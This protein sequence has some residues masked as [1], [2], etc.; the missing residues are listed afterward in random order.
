MS[1]L[2]TKKLEKDFWE[3][4]ILS[5]EEK[6]ELFNH[7]DISFYDSEKVFIIHFALIES[8][9]SGMN[10]IST[11]VQAYGI[12]YEYDNLTILLMAV[13]YERVDVV[14]YL[15]DNGADVNHHTIRNGYIMVP[16]VIA[17]QRDNIDILNKLLYAGANYY[18]TGCDI[19]TNNKH[20]SVGA[21]LNHGRFDYIYTMIAHGLDINYCWNYQD[22]TMKPYNIAFDYYTY[23]SNTQETYNELSKLIA[24]GLQK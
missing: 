2:S 11:L 22:D 1:S 21:A 13:R 14:D 5:T 15:I 20:Y 4:T 24:N 19:I 6:E 16:I 23:Y 7:I 12:D 8:K 17:C 9:F 10:I 18:N 3:T